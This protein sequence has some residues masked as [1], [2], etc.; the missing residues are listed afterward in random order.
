MGGDVTD[1]D[2]A[3]ARSALSWWLQAG[4]DVALQE[5]PR[6]WLRP[7]APRAPPSAEPPAPEPNLLQ[8]SQDT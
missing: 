4:V 5:E 1:L 3:Q 2:L 6:D 7:A 8:P